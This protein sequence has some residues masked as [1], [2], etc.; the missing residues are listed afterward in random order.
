VVVSGFWILTA[1][2]HGSTATILASVA[3]SRLATMGHAVPI[4]IMGSLIFSIATVPA[5]VVVDMLLPLVTGFDMFALVV[6]PVLFAFALLMAHKRTFLIGFFS[7]LLF[8]AVGNFQDHMTYDAVAL[9][10]TAIAAVVSTGVAFVLWAILAPDTAEVA[11]RRF[12]RVVRKI[13]ASIPAP[14]SRMGLLEFEKKMT[15]ALGQLQ[16]YMHP[17][18]SEDIACIEGGIG[19]LNAG[20]ELFRLRDKRLFSDTRE[21]GRDVAQSDEGWR[22]AWLDRNRSCVRPVAAWRLTELCKRLLAA[23]PAEIAAPQ[24]G[25]LAVIEDEL[26]QSSALLRR[27]R[28]AEVVDAG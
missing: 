22:V 26:Q 8:S 16:G 11:R 21:V 24:S 14:R 6:A 12:A 10:N 25:V 20:R 2:P 7:A 28:I 13:L 1:W 23:A 3:T 27:P 5:F 17:D 19:V 4:A 18:M 15:D 9:L